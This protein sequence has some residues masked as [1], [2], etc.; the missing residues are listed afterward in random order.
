ML[1][2]LMLSLLVYSNYSAPW[3]Q[4][5]SVLMDPNSVCGCVICCEV[6]QGYDILITW[7][8]ACIQSQPLYR[9][10]YSSQP[11]PEIELV[12]CVSRKI[13]LDAC[14]SYKTTLVSQVMCTAAMISPKQHWL[15]LTHGIGH[16]LLGCC[17][18]CTRH[19]IAHNTHDNSQHM[20]LPHKASSDFRY[21]SDD[22]V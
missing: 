1:W 6:K 18:A 3:S 15:I 19:E 10:E 14:T 17:A 11:Y 4:I 5:T 16:G 2:R 13:V 9:A 8:Q 20:S 7:I 22:Y 12:S 21:F